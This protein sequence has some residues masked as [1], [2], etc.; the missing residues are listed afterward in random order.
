ML[1]G[2]CWIPTG[3]NLAGI[4][5]TKIAVESRQDPGPYLQGRGCEE[6]SIQNRRIQRHT[7]V[8]YLSVKLL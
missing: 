4:I 8:P 2:S 1:L 6:K 3:Q 5:P 7:F